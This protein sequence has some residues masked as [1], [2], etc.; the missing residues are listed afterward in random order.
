M[1]ARTARLYTTLN[2]DIAFDEAFFRVRLSSPPSPDSVIGNNS[3]ELSV[4]LA[5]P[6]MIQPTVT[7]DTH[8]KLDWTW[9]DGGGKPMTSGGFAVSIERKEPGGGD[10]VEEKTDWTTEYSYETTLD[11]Q[12]EYRACVRAETAGLKSDYSN[13]RTFK[14]DGR[15]RAYVGR[16]LLHGLP[17]LR[18]AE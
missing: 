4:Y 6:E 16:C 13:Y 17:P 15:D 10:W 18:K 7:G 3:K 11:P 9:Q 14:T 2:A 1:T 12:V 8:V 5:E